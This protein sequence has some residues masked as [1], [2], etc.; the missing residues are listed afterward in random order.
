MGPTLLTDSTSHIRIVVSSEADARER[1]SAD[2]ATSDRPCV[3]PMRFL[4]NVPVSGD[5]ILTTFSA[6]V[7]GISNIK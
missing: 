2:Q 5:H 4:R 3:C 1:L 7:F 6:P